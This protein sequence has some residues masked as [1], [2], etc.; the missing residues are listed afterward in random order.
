MLRL[1]RL[2]CRRDSLLLLP[3]PRFELSPDFQTKLLLVSLFQSEPRLLGCFKSLLLLSPVIPGRTSDA[4]PSRRERVG[5]K[6]I[7]LSAFL[8]GRR[9][10]AVGLSSDGR[11]IL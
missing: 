3:L 2:S 5:G 11:R 9:R 8:H 1:K 7:G 6:L 10:R 4:R